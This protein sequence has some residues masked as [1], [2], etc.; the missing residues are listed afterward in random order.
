MNS[1]ES[2]EKYR[3]DFPSLKMRRNGKPP[4][5]LDNAC[6]TLVPRQVIEALNEYYTQYPSCNGG[7][8]RHWFADEVTSR[9]EGN[10]DKGIK[11][12]RRLI[13]EFINA[14]SEKEI[15]FTLNT[16]HAINTVALGFKF[17]PGDIVLLTYK[18]HNSNLVPWLKL[19]KSGLI[20]V[21][22]IMSHHDIFDLPALEQ[23]LTNNRVRLV[24]MAYTSN[25]TGYTIP[26]KEIIKLAHKYNARVLLDGA[27][28]CRIKL[29]TFETW[30]LISWLFQYIKCVGPEG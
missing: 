6:T 27:R 1:K 9:I 2:L 3:A 30:M 28:R 7:R 11:G 17:H 26:A 4:V 29:L 25:A 19:Q 21:E 5:Y 22:F 13:A 12:S 14:D 8:S 18:E 24:S 10:S 20:K 16:S 15:I 23:K